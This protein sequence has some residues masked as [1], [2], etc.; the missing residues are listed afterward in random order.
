MKCYLWLW[1]SFCI[2]YKLLLTSQVE[3]D[4]FNYISDDQWDTVQLKVR[5]LL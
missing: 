4:R 5:H 1:Y 2:N 3:E